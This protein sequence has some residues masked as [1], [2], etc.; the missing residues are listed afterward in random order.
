MKTP[1]MNASL[2]A[3]AMAGA[4]C[5]NPLVSAHAAGV[6]VGSGTGVSVGGTGAAVGVDTGVDVNTRV[7]APARA[8]ARIKA[9]ANA[10]GRVNAQDDHRARMD[11]NADGVVDSRDSRSSN[12]IPT[13]TGA[14]VNRINSGADAMVEG[15]AR[16]SSDIHNRVKGTANKAARADRLTP[17]RSDLRG[18]TTG[19]I[20]SGADTDA[21]VSGTTQ[22]GR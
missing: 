8:S 15:N 22:V 19:R 14:K 18:S 17:K 16:A 21:T 1:T 2:F 12:R 5:L 9:D 10:D 20:H 3:L 4:V 13:H 6:N 7:A 11:S